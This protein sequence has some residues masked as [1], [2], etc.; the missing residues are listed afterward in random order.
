MSLLA[1]G[2]HFEM[3]SSAPEKLAGM[4]RWLLPAVCFGVAASA[5]AVESDQFAWVR[6]I[7]TPVEVESEVWRLPLNR[8]IHAELLRPDGS[9]LLITDARD[10]PVQFARIP[11]RLL[12]PPAQPAVQ[13]AA[14]ADERARLLLT[15]NPIPE[16][17]PPNTHRLTLDGAYRVRRV[18]VRV[19]APGVDAQLSM[20]SRVTGAQTWLHR[21]S[22]ALSSPSAGEPAIATIEL[23]EGTRDREW[24]MHATPP[25]P[26]APVVVFEAD[27]EQLIF[28]AEGEPPWQLYAGSR[29]APELA[30]DLIDTAVQRFGPPE[31]WPLARLG[32]RREAAGVAAL[33][34]EPL[35]AVWVSFLTWL[36]VIGGSILVA[37]AGYRWL[38]HGAPW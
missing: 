6:A 24:R 33:A 23:T 12:E 5:N 4:I 31:S 32:E 10:R 7:E 38:R 22:A 30:D 15:V 3:R 35:S 37:W 25:L 17:S 16:T 27:A 20:Q 29:D 18:S 19:D 36:A 1:A 26:A 21:G 9:D 13:E 8:E 11:R 28:L 14:T 34:P 2:G